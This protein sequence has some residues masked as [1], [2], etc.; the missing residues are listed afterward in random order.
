MLIH[1]PL[2]R[3]SHAYNQQCGTGLAVAVSRFPKVYT[4]TESKWNFG[5]V[6]WESDRAPGFHIPCRSGN[7]S[8]AHVHLPTVSSLARNLAPAWVSG[9][10]VLSSGIA[11]T[12]PA[13]LLASDHGR[14]SEVESY[15]SGGPA[16]AQC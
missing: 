14:T 15:K 16:R 4:S 10:E 8:L 5:H 12:Q 2:A 6:A 1:L 3:I 9:Q 11:S 7:N 13:D